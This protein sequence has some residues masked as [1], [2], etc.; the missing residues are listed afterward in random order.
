MRRELPLRVIV[1]ANYEASKV[2]YPVL[3][4][5]HGLFGNC[6]NWLELTALK[7]HLAD[8]E[9]IVVLPEGGHSW[10]T[11]SATVASDKFESSFINELIPAVEA[12]YRISG[13]SAKRAIAGLSMGGFGALKFAL[14]RPDLFVFAGSMSGAF[15]APRLTGNENPADWRELFPSVLEVFGQENSPTRADNDLFRIIRKFPVAKR[16]SAPQIYFDCGTGDSFLKVN[17]ELAKSLKENGLGFNFDERAGG[18]DW[19]YWDKRLRVVLKIVEEIF[20]RK[21]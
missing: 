20:S 19:R 15:N 9:F 10:Y 4:L 5:L 1:P 3:Y 16:S 17:R 18:H 12:R 14:K 8:K 2:V 11:D 7:S 21:Q 13:D 6:D